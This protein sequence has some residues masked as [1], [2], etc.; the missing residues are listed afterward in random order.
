MEVE[1]H[2]ILKGIAR[3]ADL[4]GNLD[5]LHY[6]LTDEEAMTVDWETVGN[7]LTEAMESYESEQ[8]DQN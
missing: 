1:K 7:D 5:D 3:L 6:D 4:T 2:P 8:A